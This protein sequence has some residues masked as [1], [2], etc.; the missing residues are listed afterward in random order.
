MRTTN[1]NRACSAEIVLPVIGERFSL[2]VGRE[3]FVRSTII[4]DDVFRWLIYFALDRT[5]AG[6]ALLEL[7]YP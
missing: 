3:D 5:V 7:V 6:A 2:N 1:S 4:E